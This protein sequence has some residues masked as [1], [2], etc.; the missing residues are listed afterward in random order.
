MGR[1]TGEQWSPCLLAGVGLGALQEGAW[2]GFVG[3]AAET[4]EQW[5]WSAGVL[6]TS[7]EIC[8]SSRRLGPPRKPQSQ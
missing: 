6:A 8:S 7:L 1:K 2:R 5:P 3:V 4:K